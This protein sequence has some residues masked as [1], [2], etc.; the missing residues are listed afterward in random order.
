MLRT[1]LLYRPPNDPLGSLKQESAGTVTE[2]PR[3]S[4]EKLNAH[5]KSQQG[6]L[7]KFSGKRNIID[8]KVKFLMLYGAEVPR[9]NRGSEFV[10]TW[11]LERENS[12]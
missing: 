8:E 7:I 5:E 9:Q 10:V 12:K 11:F 4:R 6:T 2:F 1:V 3:T